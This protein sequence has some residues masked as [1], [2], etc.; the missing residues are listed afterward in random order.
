[1]SR[2]FEAFS[3]DHVRWL[4]GLRQTVISGKSQNLV[5]IISATAHVNFNSRE[6][7]CITAVKCQDRGTQ[8]TDVVLVSFS[9]VVE[10]I[11]ISNGRTQ[12]CSN[13]LR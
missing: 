11:C 6:V 10:Q 7:D 13:I 2:L 8:S 3:S 5:F 1:M 12:F 9:V 4:W